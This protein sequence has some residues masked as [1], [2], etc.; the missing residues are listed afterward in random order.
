MPRKVGQVITGGVA[1]E[2]VQEEEMDGGDRIE[3]ALTPLV[4]HLT[5]EGEN[6]GG[7]K[8][9]RELCLDVF[10]RCGDRANHPAPPV[11]EMPCSHHGTGAP[12]ESK[13]KIL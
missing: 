12:L 10:E 2:D 7:V 6:R 8:Q 9:G 11:S 3:L 1:M 5:T 13:R 4:V